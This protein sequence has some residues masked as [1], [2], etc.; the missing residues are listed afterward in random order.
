MGHM[1][2]VGLGLLS[3]KSHPLALQQQP[4]AKVL[5][6]GSLEL[7]ANA[8]DMGH[9]GHVGLGLLSHKSHLLVL[10]QLATLPKPLWRKALGLKA[11][12]W[13]M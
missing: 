7:K 5:W 8:W 13:D 1:G 3:H 6:R 10:Q 11:N 12:A 9:M 4:P 2:H